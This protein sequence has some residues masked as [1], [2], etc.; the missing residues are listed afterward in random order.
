[1]VTL[2]DIQLLQLNKLS[3]KLSSNLTL[4]AAACSLKHKLNNKLLLVLEA[5]LTTEEL[6]LQLNSSNNNNNKQQQHSR[7]F[8]VL[9]IWQR[10]PAIAMTNILQKFLAPAAETL[11]QKFLA[12]VEIW[13]K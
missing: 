10:L 1:M 2:I 8:L 12:I 11:L 6:Q 4:V 9:A 5:T 13:L 7:K 3:S